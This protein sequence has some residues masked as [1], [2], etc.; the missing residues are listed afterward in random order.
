MAGGRGGACAA[1]VPGAQQ[2]RAAGK[3]AGLYIFKH[4]TRLRNCMIIMALLF[5]LVMASR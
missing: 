1:R 4:L 5:R 2:A 3:R